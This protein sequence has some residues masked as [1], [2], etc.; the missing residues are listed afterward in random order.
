MSSKIILVL[1]STLGDV[2]NKSLEK[3]QNHFLL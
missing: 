3:L 2:E 1:L